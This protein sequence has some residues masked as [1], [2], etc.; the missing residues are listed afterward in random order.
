MTYYLPTDRNIHVLGR[1]TGNVPLPLFWTGSGMELYTDS[2]TLWFE[3]ETDYDIQEEWIRIEVDG[4]CMQRMLLPKGRSRICAFRGWPCGTIR[5]IRLLKEVQPIR[6]DEKKCLLVHGLECDGSLYAPPEKKY[7]IEFIGDS[8][9]AGEGLGGA[10][11]LLDVGPA[12][13]GLESH[14]AL[15]V[16]EHF[17]ADFRILAQSGWGVY[18]ASNNDLVRIMPKYYEQ[19]CGTV[20]GENNK[21]LMAFNKNDFNS[22][23]PD[24][25]VVNLGSNDGFAMD[26][27]AWENPEDGKFY[28]QLEN[29]YGGMEEQSA[30]RFEKSVIAFLYKLRQ[31]NPQAYILWAYG[32]CEHRMAPYLEKAVSAYAKESGDERAAF[33][34]LPM[35]M[36]MWTGCNHHPGRKDHEMAAK[37]LIYA[38]ES[39]LKSGAVL[40]LTI[41]KE[42]L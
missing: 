33:Q 36:P 22:W 1:T 16:A 40:D 28:K 3:L 18:C 31:L 25:I 6:E 38:L 7:K 32:M 14:Y 35:M 26:K 19:I 2:G 41:R 10:P 9:S 30:V 34:I 42:K 4:F 12:A 17:R 37:V 23:Q 15:L 11:T 24:I 29:P 5:R 13:F 27:P 39:A 8:I 20:A 21:Q